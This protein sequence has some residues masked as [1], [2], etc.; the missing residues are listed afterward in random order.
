[1]A[2]TLSHHPLNPDSSSESEDDDDKIL[3]NHFLWDGLPI[4]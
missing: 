2:D 3:G 1:M 4:Y